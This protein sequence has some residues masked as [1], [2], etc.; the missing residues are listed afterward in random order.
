MDVVHVYAAFK[1]LEVFIGE[2]EIRRDMN[3]EESVGGDGETAWLGFNLESFICNTS[4]SSDVVDPTFRSRDLSFTFPAEKL[5]I[6]SSPLASGKTALLV[7]TQ[8][9]SL[10]TFPKVSIPPI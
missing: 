9:F 3:G 2:E 7:R 5:T 4:D 10:F 6:V 1:K 8:P